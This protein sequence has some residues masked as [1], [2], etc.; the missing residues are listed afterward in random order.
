MIQAKDNLDRRALL[1]KF[2]ILLGICS[3]IPMLFIHHASFFFLY[4]FI[5]LVVY[6]HVDILKIVGIN[7]GI[8]TEE[9]IPF[10]ETLLSEELEIIKARN[11]NKLVFQQPKQT[12]YIDCTRLLLESSVIFFGFITIFTSDLFTKTAIA[13]NIFFKTWI[14]L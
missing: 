14:C 13:C 10:K 8:T 5:Q 6:L 9:V 11:D 7:L 1:V 3:A 4:V 12:F 2:T